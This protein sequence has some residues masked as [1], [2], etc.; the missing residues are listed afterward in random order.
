ME[1]HSR[2]RRAAG[3]RL[4][5]RATHWPNATGSQLTGQTGKY[6]PAVHS[7][8]QDFPGGRDGKVSA[9]N[10]G[11]PGLIPGSGRSSGGGNGNP[12]QYSCLETPMDRG[13]WWA[14]VH[15]VARVGHDWASSLSL[16]SYSVLVSNSPVGNGQRWDLKAN[17]GL[18]QNREWPESRGAT[19]NNSWGWSYWV[20]FEPEPEDQEAAMGSSEESTPGRESARVNVLI[21]SEWIRFCDSWLLITR[22]VH[23]NTK[24]A[25]LNRKLTLFS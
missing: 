4:C 13:P 8:S 2:Q 9:Y 16:L 1:T 24:Q 21:S 25:G 12:L 23:S 3:F 19:L 11:D 6:G 17:L 10:A 5:I 22:K 20:M 14:M 7:Q 15:G 18:H